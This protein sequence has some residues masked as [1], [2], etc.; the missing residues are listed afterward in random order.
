[1]NSS[2]TFNLS[3]SYFV[4]QSK[5]TKGKFVFDTVSPERQVT[6]LFD[7][8]CDRSSTTLPSGNGK[9]MLFSLIF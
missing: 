4:L 9:M 7:F 2:N 8:Q 5:M 1:M 6:L 3:P